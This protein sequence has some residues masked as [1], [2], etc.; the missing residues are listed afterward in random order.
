MTLVWRP[1]YT[2]NETVWNPS[3]ITTALWLDAADVST[4]AESGGA[5]SQ[6]DDKS[7]NSLVF[8]QS[9]A[10]SR[11]STGINTLGG[12]N[13]LTLNAANSQC[14][15][16]GNDLNYVFTGDDWEIFY[17]CRVAAID[18]F[19]NA[20]IGKIG[21]S[22]QSENQRQFIL[23]LRDLGGLETAQLFTSYALTAS[24]FTSV[25]ASTTVSANTYYIFSTAYD[26]SA[27]A[28]GGSANTALRVQHVINGAAQSETVT[29]SDGTLGDIPTGAAR[30]SVG[31]YVGTAGTVYSAP[32]G[33]DIAEIVVTPSMLSP[34]DRQ[35]I[36]G[37]L[38]HKWGLT[39]NL[40]SDHPYKTVGPTP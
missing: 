6:W 29:L 4:I 15:I 26:K 19:S 21:D 34:A 30:L 36:E 10:A 1:G 23:N 12:K 2:W 9:V 24:A 8:S 28:N 31:A 22:T 11:P 5:V 3:M 37:Y 14:L 35:K 16:A 17:V 40:P 32:F 18:G 39:A 7:P 33:G 20:L 38:A 27:A 25:A 13:V